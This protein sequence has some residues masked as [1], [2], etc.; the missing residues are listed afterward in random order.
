MV[1][2]VRKFKTKKP[3]LNW[4]NKM[5]NLTNFRIIDIRTQKDT[6]CIVYETNEVEDEA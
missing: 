4:L 2:Q 6:L 5:H 3:F 1:Y